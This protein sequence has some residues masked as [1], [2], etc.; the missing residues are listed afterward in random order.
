MFQSGRPPFN[1]GATIP[2]SILPCRKRPSREAGSFCGPKA[3]AAARRPFRALVAGVVHSLTGWS[4]FRELPQLSDDAWLISRHGK[5]VPGLNQSNAAL[6]LA[7]RKGDLRIIQ[8]RGMVI[9]HVCQHPLSI[10]NAARKY[11]EHN[12]RRRN[13]ALIA[14]GARSADPQKNRS[15]ISSQA[16]LLKYL[17]QN[18]ADYGNF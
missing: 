17:C 12:D 6:F 1:A 4:A 16:I 8:S 5:W 3:A 13:T 18:V 9:P 2:P 10:S 7:G 15:I 14:A 11:C